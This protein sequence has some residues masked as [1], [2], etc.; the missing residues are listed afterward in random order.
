MKLK[1]TLLGLYNKY[2]SIPDDEFKHVYGRNQAK[3]KTVHPEPD[4]TAEQLNRLFLTLQKKQLLFEKMLDFQVTD[5]SFQISTD[6]RANDIAHKFLYM[7]SALSNTPLSLLAL[8]LAKGVSEDIL[9]LIAEH[10]RS[11]KE[12]VFMTSILVQE[13]VLGLI[14]DRETNYS[15][16]K[17]QI[18]TTLVMLI[19]RFL[20]EKIDQ[21]RITDAYT[22]NRAKKNFAE[23]TKFYEGELAT[24]VVFESLQAARQE[25]VAFKEITKFLTHAG[26]S[27]QLA[28]A[29]IFT[30]TQLMQ[31]HTNQQ[32]I[33][34]LLRA[35]DLNGIYAAVL[36][37][38]GDLD[39]GKITQ[40]IEAGSE[41]IH[42]KVH[43]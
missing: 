30:L 38:S 42:L 27:Q 19:T 41:K 12:L 36:S 4:V 5:F 1:E 34:T 18:D 8:L 21:E 20:R 13:Q 23:R 2:F 43:S 22:K 31:A 26:I 39:I 6:L 16:K 9:F 7:P 11:P 15:S 37:Q 35:G 10:A 33:Q 32:G 40:D 14:Q 17:A 25:R 29:K 3:I 28:N 24:Q